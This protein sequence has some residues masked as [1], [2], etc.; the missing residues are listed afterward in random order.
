MNL[1]MEVSFVWRF[2][3]TSH[4]GIFHGAVL[5]FAE[6]RTWEYTQVKYLSKIKKQKSPEK[7]NTLLLEVDG[8]NGSMV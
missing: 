3:P 6:L 2:I 4:L 7:L 1:Q 5:H 8:Q